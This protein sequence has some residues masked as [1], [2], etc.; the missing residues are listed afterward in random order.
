MKNRNESSS[1]LFTEEQGRVLTLLAKQTI[2]K[3]FGKILPNPDFGV[4]NAGLA[5]FDFSHQCGTFV[6]LHINGQLRGCI[7]TLMPMESVLSGIERNAVQAAFHDPRFPPLSKEELAEIDI[8]ISVLTSPQPLDYEEYD[9]LLTQLRP[10]IDGVILRKGMANATFLPQVWDQL[11]RSEDFL[12]R[13][14][15][16]AGLPSD[17]WRTTRLE[18]STYQVQYFTESKPAS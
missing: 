8:E 5:K 16:K 12:S 14:C 11:P 9:D 17:N 4:L 6:T 15:M 18:V 10:R 1:I 2:M 13:L 3:Q 7:G